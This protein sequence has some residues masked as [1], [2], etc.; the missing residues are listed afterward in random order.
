MSGW[1][2]DD[3]GDD[4]RLAQALAAGDID[5]LTQVYDDHAAG[6][7]DYCHALLPDQAA[8][9]AALRDTLLAACA[10]AGRLTERHLLRAWLYALARNECLRRRRSR[11]RHGRRPEH[12][13]IV[14]PRTGEARPPE[15]APE[16]ED[17]ALD[18]SDRARRKGTRRQVH[19]ALAGLR[20]REREAVDL[21]VR[22]GLTSSELA[23][24]FDLNE[25]EAAELAERTLATV[26]DALRVPAVAELEHCPE[27]TAMVIGKR[28][29]LDPEV[30]AGVDAHMAEGCRICAQDRARL[31]PGSLLRALPVA[32]VPSG[33][34]A[35]VIGA[36]AGPGGE[37]ARA[38]AAENAEPFDEWGWPLP[39]DAPAAHPAAAAPRR[40]ASRLLPL[41]AVAAAVVMVVGGAFWLLPGGSESAAIGDPR[42]G[43]SVPSGESGD[44][45]PP[46]TPR[47]SPTPD[48]RSPS[49]SPTSPSASPTTGS[50]SPSPTASASAPTSAPTRTPAPP[51]PGPPPPSPPAR[52]TLEVGG[53]RMDRGQ[54]SC[55]IRVTARGGT[56]RWSVRGTRGPVRAGGGGTLSAGASAYVTVT[57]TG[58][59]DEDESGVVYF[60]PNG[61]AGVSWECRW[62]R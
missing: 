54:D 7:Y 24:V 44:P 19:G 27:V 56:V 55:S 28:R 62:W 8:A 58:G 21:L 3:R 39:L 36:A 52:G 22:H 25:A 57:R 49:E 30:V 15:R 29:P 10:H 26:Y 50:P 14:D 53:C 23:G 42:P 12:G 13:W 51:R 9:A 60:S 34:R 5:A 61:A 20:H 31:D 45:G 6:L 48:D 38:V 1:S 11:D 18:E 47:R 37:E 16:A 35:E 43:T 46:E 32:L 33:L 41:L 2:S 4:Q 59:C 40:R 17:A